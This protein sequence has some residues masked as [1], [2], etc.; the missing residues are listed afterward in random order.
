MDEKH[1]KIEWLFPDDGLPRLVGIPDN[2]EVC[3]DS[4]FF[5]A[6]EAKTNNRILKAY[7]YE[8]SPKYL[9]LY[10]CH[11]IGNHS[12]PKATL[13]LSLHSQFDPK[14][15][16]SVGILRLFGLHR[17]NE[18]IYE[19]IRIT[20]S[21]YWIECDNTLFFEE[22]GVNQDQELISILELLMNI[23]STAQMHYDSDVFSI[24]QT[25]ISAN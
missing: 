14:V 21:G 10:L 12:Y 13:A 23:L 3:I 17:E 8:P 9:V 22:Y 18:I 24:D 11:M 6:L 1:I 2:E 19:A 25:Q 4:D 16:E 5:K 20:W 7:I 15:F